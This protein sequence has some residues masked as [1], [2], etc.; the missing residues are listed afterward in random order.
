MVDMLVDDLLA[1]HGL[2]GL[3]ARSRSLR[4]AISLVLAIEE[5]LL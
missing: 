4:V 3:K 5:L 2:R 1:R